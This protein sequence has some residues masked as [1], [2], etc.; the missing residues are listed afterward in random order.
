MSWWCHCC[1]LAAYH[2]CLSQRIFCLQQLRAGFLPPGEDFLGEV[3]AHSVLLKWEGLIPRLLRKSLGMRLSDSRHI[4]FM[5]HSRQ[6]QYSTW[7]L[8]PLCVYSHIVDSLYFVLFDYTVFVYDSHNCV[9][10]HVCC[11]HLLMVFVSRGYLVWWIVC[12]CFQD[13][14]GVDVLP[15]IYDGAIDEI[16]TGLYTINHNVCI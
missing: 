12:L 7:A 3:N 15:Q 1:T 4:M 16:I 8:P 11:L 2:W 9:C 5:D 14:I 6:S 13:E 10:M